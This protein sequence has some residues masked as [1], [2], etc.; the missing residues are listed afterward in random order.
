MLLSSAA[1]AGAS[2]SPD[3]PDRSQPLGATF[4]HLRSS[5]TLC[6]AEPSS[7]K[8]RAKK[9][10]KEE[11]EEAKRKTSLTPS[12]VAS[13]DFAEV[14]DSHDVESMPTYTMEQVNGNDG[15]D[16]KRIW[17]TYGGYVYDVT[18]FI[19]NHP[20]G[21]EKI[22]LASGGAIEPFWYVVGICCGAVSPAVR[23]VLFFWSNCCEFP[24]IA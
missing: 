2:G 12:K 18:D 21:D 11:E 7:K 6:E 1:A 10:K 14:Q 13:E 19:P 17:M 24:P 16:G 5:T 4:P 8:K 15:E 22:R 3:S 23:G 20:G 9:K